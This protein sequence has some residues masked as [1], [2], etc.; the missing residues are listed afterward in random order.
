M[1][2]YAAERGEV[3]DADNARYMHRCEIHMRICTHVYVHTRMYVC[4]HCMHACVCTSGVSEHLLKMMPLRRWGWLL[5]SK[6]FLFVAEL[7]CFHVNI[8]IAVVITC[9]SLTFGSVFKKRK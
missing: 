6:R 8:I 5:A 1:C 7:F 9:C 3:D 2:I 4:M